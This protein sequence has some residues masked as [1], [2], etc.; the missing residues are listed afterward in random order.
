M[1]RF[2]TCP[3]GLVWCAYLCLF[4]FFFF[5][6]L[7]ILGFKL[8]KCKTHANTTVTSG[9]TDLDAVAKERDKFLL[10]FIEARTEAKSL[11]KGSC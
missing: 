2:G 10:G 11:E 6:V 7:T 8:I 5:S 1:P 4:L 9:T 3:F